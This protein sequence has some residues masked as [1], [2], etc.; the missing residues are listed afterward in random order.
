[1][2]NIVD[3]F[4]CGMSHA[5]PNII[6]NNIL[7]TIIKGKKS[8]NRTVDRVKTMIM[9]DILECLFGITKWINLLATDV[10]LSRRPVSINF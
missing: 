10:T 6:I 8:F 7:S 2:R 4:L 5:L 3:N 9:Y 1:M